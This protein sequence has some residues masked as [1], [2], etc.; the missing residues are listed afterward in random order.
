MQFLIW[1][2]KDDPYL[3]KLQVIVLSVGDVSQTVVVV[4]PDIR[5][6]GGDGMGEVSE[7]SQV[8]FTN[9][10]GQLANLT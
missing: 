7:L 9:T 1:S 3:E 2:R 4:S 8:N 5:A 6:K 10:L